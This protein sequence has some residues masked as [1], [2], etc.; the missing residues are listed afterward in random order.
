MLLPE[1]GWLHVL[2]HPSAFGDGV[3]PLLYLLCLSREEAK[4]MWEKREAEWAR[5][6]IARDKLM[7]E[8]IPKNMRSPNPSPPSMH[9]IW[10]VFTSM[11]LSTSSVATSTA[12]VCSS[13]L[14]RAP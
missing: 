3:E 8:V 1:V 12:A 11:S 13:T 6:Q 10:S 5:E 14:K 9:L 7:S 4:E 2:S